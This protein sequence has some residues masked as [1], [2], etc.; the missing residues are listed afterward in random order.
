MISSAGTV[1]ALIKRLVK[2]EGI[3]EVYLGVSH[4]LCVGRARERLLTLQKEYNLE[5]TIITNS[6]PQTE[7]FR[8]LPFVSERCL[9]D[10]L[11]RTINR[12]HYNQ[13][14]SEVFYGSE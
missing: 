4:N 6:I 11:S 2:D 5:Q 9:S 14:V 13:S 1:F 3:K 7:E 12:I 8:S 10:I